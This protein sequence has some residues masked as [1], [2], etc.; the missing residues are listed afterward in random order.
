MRGESL[1]EDGT[2]GSQLLVTSTQS[3]NTFKPFPMNNFDFGGRLDVDSSENRLMATAVQ[4]EMKLCVMPTKWHTQEDRPNRLRKLQSRNMLGED[5]TQLADIKDPRKFWEKLMEIAPPRTWTDMAKVFSFLAQTRPLARPSHCQI[6]R[7]AHDWLDEAIRV[8]SSC[9]WKDDMPIKTRSTTPEF[10]EAIRIMG[11]ARH[12]YGT[13]PKSIREKII[14]AGFGWI[15]VDPKKRIIPKCWVYWANLN[16]I[17]YKEAVAVP[18]SYELSA[19]I[20]DSTKISYKDA[21]SQTIA[22]QKD[23]TSQTTTSQKDA[24]SQT[25]AS[26]NPS[27]TPARTIIGSSS[28]SQPSRIQS[29]RIRQPQ[30]G[31][32]TTSQLWQITENNLQALAANQIEVYNSIVEE[33]QDFVRKALEDATANGPIERQIKHVINKSIVKAYDKGKEQTAARIDAKLDEMD[34]KITALQAKTGD[35]MDDIAQV[36]DRHKRAINDVDRDFAEE[37]VGLKRQRPDSFS[38]PWDDQD[39]DEP[40]DADMVAVDSQDKEPSEVPMTPIVVPTISRFRTP[41]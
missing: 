30:S 4:Q 31:L 26:Q 34:A 24:T 39:Q 25:S 12:G 5:E 8:G 29:V 23:A 13:Y 35:A 41:F 14:D 40:A 27:T 1:T 28:Q 9:D 2:Q 18:C 20:R 36:F 38:N 21:A 11:D 7:K 10:W 22:S 16:D 15:A 19:P 33:T 32:N 3:T 6:W 37:K 17:P